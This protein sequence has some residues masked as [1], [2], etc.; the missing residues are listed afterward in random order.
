MNPELEAL[1]KAYLA[2]G[3][4]DSGIVS[5]YKSSMIHFWKTLCKRRQV[6]RVTC[7]LRVFAVARWPS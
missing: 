1:I 7:L 2:L 5:G 3:E 4:C 6:F